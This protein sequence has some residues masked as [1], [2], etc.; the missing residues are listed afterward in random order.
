[1]RRRPTTCVRTQDFISSQSSPD[2]TVGLPNL[3]AGFTASADR[4]GIQC[5]AGFLLSDSPPPRLVMLV[6]VVV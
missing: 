2:D 6:V 5:G 1:M 4:R 3:H